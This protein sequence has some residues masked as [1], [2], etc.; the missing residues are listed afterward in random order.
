MFYKNKINFHFPGLF[1]FCFTMSKFSLFKR[2]L[3]G[4]LEPISKTNK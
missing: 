3:F 1:L 4:T 2:I